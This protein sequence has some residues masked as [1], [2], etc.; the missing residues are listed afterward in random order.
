MTKLTSNLSEILLVKQFI[1][2]F[3]NN[4]CVC[5][6]FK[7]SYHYILDSFHNLS[8]EMIYWLNLHFIIF[9][10]FYSSFLELQLNRYKLLIFLRLFIHQVS[11]FEVLVWLI[12]NLLQVLLSSLL[13]SIVDLYLSYLLDRHS[14]ILN[15]VLSYDLNFSVICIQMGRTDFPPPA[16]LWKVVEIVPVLYVTYYLQCVDWIQGSY[17]SC[18]SFQF[19]KLVSVHGSQSP[20]GLVTC[21][22]F[23]FHIMFPPTPLILNNCLFL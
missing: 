10:Y 18:S 13:L 21:K 15:L 11:F 2:R 12:Y 1:G 6:I 7:S 19:Y 14:L 16:V 5:S 22:C 17:W 23:V 9:T 4:L 8:Y 20:I 3:L